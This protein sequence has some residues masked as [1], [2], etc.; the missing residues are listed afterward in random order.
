MSEKVD[1]ARRALD[2]LRNGNPRELGRALDP[3]IA[4]RATGGL[5]THRYR[6]LDS[7]TEAYR[8]AERYF[9]APSLSVDALEEDEDGAVLLAGSV[10]VRHRQDGKPMR[11]AVKGVLFFRDGL[12]HKVYLRRARLE[13]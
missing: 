3:D 2:A 12:I 6:G 7:L 8:E 9:D 5:R 11:F 13:H 4:V 1:T 10:Q